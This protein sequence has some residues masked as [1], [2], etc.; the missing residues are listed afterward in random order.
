[1]EARAAERLEAVG[2][3][4]RQA[5]H[6]VLARAYRDAILAYAR[7]QGAEVVHDREDDGTLEIEFRLRE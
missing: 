2:L 5:F 1:L 7:R 3:R 4:C 6:Q